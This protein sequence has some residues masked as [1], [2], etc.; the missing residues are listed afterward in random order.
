M[1]PCNCTCRDDRAKTFNTSC[2]HWTYRENRESTWRT[3]VRCSKQR[4]ANSL[5]SIGTG[6]SSSYGQL[7]VNMFHLT[8]LEQGNLKRRKG[9]LD[10]VQMRRC[11]HRSRMPSIGTSCAELSGPLP[12]RVHLLAHGLLHNAATQLRVRIGMHSQCFGYL[13]PI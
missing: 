11:L 13:V 7:S 12:K 10:M 8:M 1:A 6:S 9:K 4:P 3:P 2:S 5:A